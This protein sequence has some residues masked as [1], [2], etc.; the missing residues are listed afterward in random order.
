[1]HCTKLPWGCLKSRNGYLLYLIHISPGMY[2]KGRWMFPSLPHF[3]A[4]FNPTLDL[5]PGESA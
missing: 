2:N 5:K 4:I 1:M 3:E